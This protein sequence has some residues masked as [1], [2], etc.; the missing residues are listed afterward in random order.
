MDREES[1]RVDRSICRSRALP[2]AN[3]RVL[4]RWE[5]KRRELPIAALKLRTCLVIVRFA[6][7]RFTEYLKVLLRSIGY[8]ATLCTTTWFMLDLPW[9]IFD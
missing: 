8:T 6:D 2:H 7:P 1:C 3:R 5:S 4:K 9:P